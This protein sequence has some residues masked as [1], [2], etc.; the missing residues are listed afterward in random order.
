MNPVLLL[1][2]VISAVAGWLFAGLVVW[3]F[4]RPYKPVKIAGICF[5]GFIPAN[6][7]KM[8]ASLSATLSKELLSSNMIRLK[9]AGPETLQKTLP[10]I[11][12][13]ID[14][15]LKVKLKAALPVIT[16]FIGER[17][18]NQL[19]ELFMKELEQLFPSVMNSFIDGLQNSREIETEIALKM[20]AVPVEIIENAFYSKFKNE[21]TNTRLAFAAAGFITGIIQVIIV[22][23]VE[24]IS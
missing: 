10:V 8:A 14:H 16:M 24:Q 18:T 6:Q 1:I 15:F 5:H 19:K 21:L 7:K 22:W 13:H 9:L 2:P 12:E 3:S 4:F 17:V 20:E 11:E 23:A